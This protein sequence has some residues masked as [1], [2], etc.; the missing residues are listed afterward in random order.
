MASTV[1]VVELAPPPE[2]GGPWP[3]MRLNMTGAAGAAE[4]WG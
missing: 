3:K 1:R 4:R 2:P